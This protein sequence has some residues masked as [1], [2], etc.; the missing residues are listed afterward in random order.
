MVASKLSWGIAVSLAL[1]SCSQ[2][3]APAPVAESTPQPASKAASDLYTVTN[4]YDGDTIDVFKNGETH[5]VRVACIDAPEIDQT[6]HGNASRQQL[7]SLLPGQVQLNVVDTD[8]YGR[9]VAEVFTPEGAYINQRMV[10]SG[11]AVVY[12]Q[13]LSSCGDRDEVLLAAEAQAQAAGVG[14]WTDPNFVMPWSY[15]RGERSPEPEPEPE[16]AAEL[17]SCVETDCDCGDFESWQ[18]AQAVLQAFAGDP[19]RLDGDGD[20]EACESLR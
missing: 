5:R 9:L 19:H 6:P 15:R 1:Y 20:G 18:Q 16:P 10:A 3:S 2:V 17:P 13:Y 12:D 14:V 8:R 7:S 11:H 4:I